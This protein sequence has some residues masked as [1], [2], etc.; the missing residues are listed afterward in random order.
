MV[1][2]L[3]LLLY[4]SKNNW[5]FS[6]METQFQNT[7]KTRHETRET[8]TFLDCKKVNHFLKLVRL[9]SDE[10]LEAMFQEV[11]SEVIT[12]RLKK[13]NSGEVITLN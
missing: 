7:N 11:E 6:K 5:I 3:H 8:K 1:I 4:L 9:A 13:L 10:Q 2:Y 12:R